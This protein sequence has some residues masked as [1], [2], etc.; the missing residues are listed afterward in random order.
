MSA[1]FTQDSQILSKIR[2]ELYQRLKTDLTA[3]ITEYE[4]EF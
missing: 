3:A 4:F 2:S 1:T